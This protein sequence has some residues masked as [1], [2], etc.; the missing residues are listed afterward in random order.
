M[1]TAYK[2]HDW[3]EQARQIVRDIRATKK[4]KL[5]FMP[6]SFEQVKRRAHGQWGRIFE[7]FEPGVTKRDP[8]TIYT[9]CPM[10]CEEWKFKFF[11]DFNET[12]TCICYVCHPRGGDGI[13]TMAWLL[14]CTQNEARELLSDLLQ[15]ERLK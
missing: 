1:W 11:D 14:D 6:L 9:T 8:S 3:L 10:C 7:L 5:L 15:T 2:N 4:S 12:G 13:A